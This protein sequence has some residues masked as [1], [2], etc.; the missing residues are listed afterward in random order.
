MSRV[1]KKKKP[2]IDFPF[3]QIARM[4]LKHSFMTDL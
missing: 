2:N 1:L 3:F 4:D